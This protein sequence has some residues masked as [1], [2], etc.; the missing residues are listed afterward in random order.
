MQEQKDKF[1]KEILG[2]KNMNELQNS[3]A[4]T[5]ALTMQ[6]KGSDL[7]GHLKLS[8]QRSKK[9]KKKK[10]IENLC[11]LWAIIKRNDISILVITEG[12][13]KRDRKYS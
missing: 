2:L 8:H 6:K 1:N 9:K 4:L 5:T 12:E 11:D 3:I 7:T 13:R 10:I